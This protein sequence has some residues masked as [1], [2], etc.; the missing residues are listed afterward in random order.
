MKAV[1]IWNIRFCYVNISSSSL[2]RESKDGF[3]YDWDTES[4][5]IEDSR[6]DEHAHKDDPNASQHDEEDVAM[7]EARKDLP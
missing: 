2:I 5:H 3:T 1:R 4:H 7:M 6:R